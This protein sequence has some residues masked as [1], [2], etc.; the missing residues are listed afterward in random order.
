MLAH[1]DA[2]LKTLKLS[3]LRSNILQ[4]QNYITSSWKDPRYPSQVHSYFILTDLLRE[5]DPLISMLVVH[6]VF[7]YFA[8]VYITWCFYQIGNTVW[9]MYLWDS[10]C[11]VSAR[12]DGI[13]HQQTVPSGAYS[14]LRILLYSSSSSFTELVPRRI[15]HSLWSWISSLL[16]SLG[17]LS[18]LCPLFSVI[19]PTLLESE[20]SVTLFH[21]TPLWLGVGRVKKFIFDNSFLYKF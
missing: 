13:V 20:L 4:W 1:I 12:T 15:K 7:V 2:M 5:W 3:F 14:L 9:N 16:R 17:L 11:N 10:V 18:P 21:V 8:F 6:C 19:S